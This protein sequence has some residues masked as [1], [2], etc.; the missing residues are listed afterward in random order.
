MEW[1]DESGTKGYCIKCRK[2]VVTD[3]RPL[4]SFEVRGC[5]DA[6]GRLRCGLCGFMARTRARH[7]LRI[8]RG[9]RR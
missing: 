5:F 1:F 3:D 6:L 4:K 2:H 7:R 8:E 9:A